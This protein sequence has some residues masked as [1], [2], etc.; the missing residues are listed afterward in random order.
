MGKN[1]NVSNRPIDIESKLVNNTSRC[2]LLADLCQLPLPA[3]SD[4]LQ[5][6]AI[7]RFLAIRLGALYEFNRCTMAF[8]SI[9]AVLSITK[10]R[11]PGLKGGILMLQGAIVTGG[12]LVHSRTELYVFGVGEEEATYSYADAT[13]SGDINGPAAETFIAVNHADRSQTHYGF[14]TFAGQVK[15]RSGTLTWKFK[16]KPGTGQIEILSGTGELADLK[17]TISYRVMEGSTTEFSYSGMLR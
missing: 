3:V 12:I 14:G 11:R 15:G 7:V 17:G 1:Q 2:R 8:I 6:V 16:G 10:G 4:P 9:A 5:A 13:Y